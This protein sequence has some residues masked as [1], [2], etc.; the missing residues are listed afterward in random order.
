M[1]I[2]ENSDSTC[3]KDAKW[4]PLPSLGPIA[5]SASQGVVG[6]G[7]GHEKGSEMGVPRR[8][9]KA[10]FGERLKRDWMKLNNET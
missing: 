9:R 1:H 2:P 8:R 6:V 7:P 10:V 5:P 3:A 4:K